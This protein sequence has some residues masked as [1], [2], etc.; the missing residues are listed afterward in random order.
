[1][2]AVSGLLGRLRKPQPPSEPE[3][4]LVYYTCICTEV[5]TDA[6]P[7]YPKPLVYVVKTSAHDRETLELLVNDKRSEEVDFMSR[8]EV[9]FAFL[10]MMIVAEDFRD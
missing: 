4:V 2:S 3:E 5:E 7:L 1:M 8:L 6:E 10:G 9:N